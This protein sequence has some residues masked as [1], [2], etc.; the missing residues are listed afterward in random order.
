[1]NI[2]I[3]TLRFT[4]R[5]IGAAAIRNG[6]MVLLD[7]RFLNAAH[8][9]TVPAA[10]NYLTK[11]LDQ[12]EP[13]AVAFDAPETSDSLETLSGQV[14]SAMEAL[15]TSRGIPILHLRRSDILEAF[16]VKEVVDRRQL[17]ELMDILWPNLQQMRGMVKPYAA[18]AA[19]AALVGEC[20]LTLDA[21][22]S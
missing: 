12:T 14:K 15:L 3:L 20:S 2:S 18:D 8:E 9:R 6:E 7:G 17:R 10:L 22:H 21:P 16:G 11:L 4:R 1:M 13:S 5:A 19:A